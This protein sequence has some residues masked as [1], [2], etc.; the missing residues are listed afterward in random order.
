MSFPVREIGV[1][2]EGP[3]RGGQG[4]DSLVR[5]VTTHVRGRDLRDLIAVNEAQIPPHLYDD[6][7]E[8]ILFRH[9]QYVLDDA[10]LGS[11][12][13]HDGSANFKG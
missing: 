6:A 13:T 4:C 10:E 9:L 3:V 7:I 2:D 11:C 12:R 1:Q 8:E 5:K